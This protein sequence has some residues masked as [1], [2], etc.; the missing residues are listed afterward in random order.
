MF[1]WVRLKVC[2][3]DFVSVRRRPSLRKSPCFLVYSR[4]PLFQRQSKGVVTWNS[5]GW[6]HSKCETHGLQLHAHLLFSLDLFTCFPW[7]EGCREKGWA[8]HTL[9]CAGCI[10]SLTSVQWSNLCQ[11]L[12]LSPPSH[13]LNH[14][15]FLA[16]HNNTGTF[17]YGDEVKRWTAVDMSQDWERERVGEMG[18]GGGVVVVHACMHQTLGNIGK[19]ASLPLWNK[20]RDDITFLTVER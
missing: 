2:L 4:L 12:P 5:C 16:L 14:S 8:A 20:S 9:L 3:W 17:E 18:K 15:I 10:T 11:F 7:I 6:L 13:W 1:G 19:F